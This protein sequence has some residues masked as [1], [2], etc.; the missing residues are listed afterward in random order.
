MVADAGTEM[1]AARQI[2]EGDVIEDQLGRRWLAVREVTVDADPPHS[3]YSFYGEGPD[4]RMT[5]EGTESVRR[6]K[7]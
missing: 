3:V 6:R 7:R 2:A 5:F 1:V 4:D